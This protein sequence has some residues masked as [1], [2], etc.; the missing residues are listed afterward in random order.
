MEILHVFG[1]EW[2]L[3]VAQVVNFSIVLFVLYRYA[4]KP[5]FALLEKRQQQITKGLDDAAIA[6]KERLAAT[7]EKGV[8]L[9]AA[10]SEGGK[11]MED[12]RKVAVAQEHSIIKDAQEK[13]QAILVEARTQAEGERAQMLR[14]S[15]QE[16][17]RMAV[18]AAEKI[19][20]AGALNKA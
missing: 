12:L 10:R 14:E 16:V 9:E 2:K 17:A 8:I 4:Y 20:R 15:E 6:A 7:N 3:L 13:H 1:V 19:L 18:L 11:I 5:I